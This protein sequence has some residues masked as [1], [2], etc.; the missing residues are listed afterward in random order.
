MCDFVEEMIMKESASSAKEWLKE[1]LKND[2]IIL[3]ELGYLP[4]DHRYTHLFFQ[5]I[6]G[7]YEYRSVLIT[8]NKMP[9]QWGNYFGDESVAMA[10]LDRLMHHA[11][12]IVMNG[13]SLD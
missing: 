2:L 9:T 3:D 13:D 12:V 4:I 6:N 10:I 8:S 7:C 5:F 11:E 1:L